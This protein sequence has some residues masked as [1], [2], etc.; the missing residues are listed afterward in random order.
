MKP[1]TSEPTLVNVLVRVCGVAGGAEKAPSSNVL[2]WAP[3]SHRGNCPF[4]DGGE[5]RLSHAVRE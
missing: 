2:F 5:G 3:K 4:W 1:K